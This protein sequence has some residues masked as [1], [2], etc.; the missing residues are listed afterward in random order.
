LGKEWE[1]EGGGWGGHL[2]HCL[3]HFRRQLCLFGM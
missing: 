2:L 1:R 3:R